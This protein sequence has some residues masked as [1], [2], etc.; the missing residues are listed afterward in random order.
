M[1]QLVFL[2]SKVSEL[3][4]N[5]LIETEELVNQK[6][7]FLNKYKNILPKEERKKLIR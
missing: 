6:K 5:R 7:E 4:K 3:K 1:K 2:K